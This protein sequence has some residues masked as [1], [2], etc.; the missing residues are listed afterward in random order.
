MKTIRLYLDTS[1]IGGY[2][3]CEFA[4]VTKQLFLAITDG[5]YVGV[6]SDLVVRELLHAPPDVRALVESD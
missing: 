3:D 4:D 6:I 5:G 2:Y 1:V